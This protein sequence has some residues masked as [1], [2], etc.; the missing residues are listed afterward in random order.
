MCESYMEVLQ[1]LTQKTMQSACVYIQTQN[2]SSETLHETLKYAHS[3]IISVAQ[4]VS[5]SRG[6]AY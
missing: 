5:V 1:I 4:N 3:G 2:P 6:D